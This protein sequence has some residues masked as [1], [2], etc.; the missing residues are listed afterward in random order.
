[1][2]DWVSPFSY[3][4]ERRVN[5]E[6]QVALAFKDEPWFR[7]DTFTILY[8]DPMTGDKIGVDVRSDQGMYTSVIRAQESQ[9]DGYLNGYP[10]QF[11]TV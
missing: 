11:K 8:T 9:P 10:V 1:M 2:Q 7:E 3:P 6:R 5:L 4:S